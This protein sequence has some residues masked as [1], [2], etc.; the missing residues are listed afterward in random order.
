MHS[1]VFAQRVEFR[2]NILIRRTNASRF[3]PIVSAV[4]NGLLTFRSLLRLLR[5]SRRGDLMVS[6]ELVFTYIRVFISKLFRSP[7]I[8]IVYDI[9]PDV[10]WQLDVLPK[11][12][13]IIRLWSF[14]N[15]FVFSQAKK[16]V[17]LSGPWF[18]KI[19]YCP[20]SLNNMSLS[21]VVDIDLIKPLDKCRIGFLIFTR[22]ICCYVLRQSRPVS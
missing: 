8:L 2:D 5:S 17:V 10:I 22:Q 15:R 9:Y 19:N 13:L 14:A 7:Y 4:V 3:W 20:E 6:T 21:L 18:L 1:P 16:I 12:N 11:T